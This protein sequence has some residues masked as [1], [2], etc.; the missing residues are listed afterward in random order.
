MNLLLA[1]HVRLDRGVSIGRVD[2]N[3]EGFAITA[4]DVAHMGDG[5]IVIYFADDPTALTGWNLTDGRGRTTQVR[6][7][8][9]TSRSGL[10]PSLFVVADPRKAAA[11]RP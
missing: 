2:A 7:G 3:A 11:D 1:K 8:P 5:R 10:D 9:L 4:V 6:L